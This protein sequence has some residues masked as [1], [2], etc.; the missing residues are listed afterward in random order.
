[1]VTQARHLPQQFVSI[2]VDALTVDQLSFTRP[3]SRDLHEQPCQEADEEADEVAG[4]GA[5]AL[6]QP[7]CRQWASHSQTYR[8]CREKQRSSIQSVRDFMKLMDY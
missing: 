2:A 3:P 6:A 4:E 5:V 8:T 1:M 7:I